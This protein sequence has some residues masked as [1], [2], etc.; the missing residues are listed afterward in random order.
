MGTCGCAPGPTCTPRARTTRP[1]EPPHQASRP[2]HAGAGRGRAPATPDAHSQ[3][4]LAVVAWP[5]RPG[6]GRAL[7]GVRPP[8]RPGAHLPLLQADA[9]LDHPA[10]PPPRA[11]RSL[12]LAGAAGLHPT[13]PGPP[14]DR[15]SAPAVGA[16]PASGPA[17]PHPRPRAPGVSAP[18]GRP[19]HARQRAKTLRPLARSTA[20]AP[21]RPSATLPGQQKGR[22][23]RSSRRQCAHPIRRGGAPLPVIGLNRKL[24]GA[25][26]K[27]MQQLESVR[28]PP[29]AVVC[30]V[31]AVPR[32]TGGDAHS[33]RPWRRRRRWRSGPRS[34]SG[35]P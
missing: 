25:S 15:G 24:S 30:G 34:R 22:L 7:A 4:A 33:S 3:A 16:A 12:D 5:W 28:C 21:F 10:R 13:P 20:R 14:R 29:D 2:R 23:T 32:R 11:G 31:D 9:Q 18:P 1:R 17:C 19:R 26:T 6:P 27:F 35:G 8:V